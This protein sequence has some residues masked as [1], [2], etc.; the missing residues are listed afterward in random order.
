MSKSKKPVREWM[1]ETRCYAC[2]KDIC[3][4]SKELWRYKRGYMTSRKVFCS[5]KC[6]RE[7]DRSTEQKS[8]AKKR[9][10][11]NLDDDT[12]Q[13]KVRDLIYDGMTDQQIA[14]KT[15]IFSENVKKL[16]IRIEE[17]LNE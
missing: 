15:G 17:G 1:Y 16:R 12:T 6:M 4:V 11:G 14:R 8:L 3:A 10:M 7:F 13:E 5:W 2:G 9:R